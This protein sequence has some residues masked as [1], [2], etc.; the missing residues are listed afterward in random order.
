MTETARPPR[1][2]LSFSI[3]GDEV[4]YRIRV[5]G[6]GSELDGVGLKFQLIAG[7]PLSDR[8]RAGVRDAFTIALHM[9]FGTL[10]IDASEDVVASIDLRDRIVCLISD[11]PENE[12]QGIAQRTAIESIA[13]DV[14][15]AVT[16]AI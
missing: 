4:R 15:V 10:P 2:L 14:G 12:P 16:S 3:R 6:P 1:T 7:D 11:V 5:D 8:W 9:A 13:R